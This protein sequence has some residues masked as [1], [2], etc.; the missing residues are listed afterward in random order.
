[1]P[2]YEYE[3]TSC[4]HQFDMMQKIT[5]PPI[6]QCPQC[7]EETAKRLISAAG[8]QLK[9]SGWYATD[10]KNSGKSGLNKENAANDSNDAK[11]PT[12]KAIEKKPTETKSSTKTNTKG[13][14]E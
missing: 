12:D 5:D 6:K 14:K 13:D 2:I 1:M 8:F 7:F 3:C 11:S 4:H 9:G 10:F